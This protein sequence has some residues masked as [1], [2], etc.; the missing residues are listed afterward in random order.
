MT[1]AEIIDEIKSLPPNDQREVFIFVAQ[2]VRAELGLPPLRFMPDKEFRAIAKK[3]FDENG[4]L[5]RK[6]AAHE[7]A[8]RGGNAP[9]T[10]V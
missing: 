4:E 2:F 9:E 3:I 6:L 7:R 10:L 5:V 8:E 1:A